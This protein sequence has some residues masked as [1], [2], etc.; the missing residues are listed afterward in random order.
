MAYLELFHRVAGHV[1]RL[2]VGVEFERG[3][4][5]TDDSV[6]RISNDDFDFSEWPDPRGARRMAL[7][8]RHWFSFHEEGNGDAFCLDTALDPPPVVFDRCGWASREFRE[9][10]RLRVR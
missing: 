4:P 7:R 2:G 3:E 6:A 1:R 9:P 8:M 10:V 5:L